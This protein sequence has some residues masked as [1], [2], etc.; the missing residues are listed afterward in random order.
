MIDLEII[1]HYEKIKLFLSNIKYI[2]IDDVNIKRRIVN[3]IELYFSK[4][5]DSEYAVENNLTSS[6]LSDGRLLNIGDFD[7]YKISDYIDLKS[8]MKLGS[9][10]IFLK[11]L[12]IKTEKLEYTD[13]YQTL[14]YILG[15]IENELQEFIEEDLHSVNLQIKFDLEK[16]QL[17]KL[18]LLSIVKDNYSTNF[19]DISYDEIILLQIELVLALTK[20]TTKKT[21]ILIDLPYF[22]NRWNE[23]LNIFQ[24]NIYF[25]IFT[26]NKENYKNIVL[27]DIFILKDNIKIDLYDDNTIYNLCLNEDKN[28]TI[29]E[30]RTYLIEKLIYK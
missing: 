17:I 19:L 7:F 1:T 28:Y 21:I 18:L 22:N 16:K 12:E 5:K 10:S 6:L 30:Y 24:P 27:K 11:Y 4:E 15:D 8:E 9:K 25:L 14:S 26:L 23:L 29:E 2:Y 20:N 3:T 13:S